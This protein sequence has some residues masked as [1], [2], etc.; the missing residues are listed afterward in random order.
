M[1]TSAEYRVVMRAR[2][3]V[4]AVAGYSNEENA[5]R[6]GTHP[7]TVR[8]T[9]KRAKSAKL[10]SAWIA[11]RSARVRWRLVNDGEQRSER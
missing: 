7:D 4:D 2:I 5:R 6:N 3:L 8:K 11:M 1:A 9:R 10:R